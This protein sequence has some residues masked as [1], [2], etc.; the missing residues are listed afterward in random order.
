MPGRS[1]RAGMFERALNSV[2]RGFVAMLAAMLL[3]GCVSLPSDFRQPGVT[4][5]SI[6][7]RVLDSMTPEFDILL[8]VTNPNRKALEISGLIYEVRLAG[9]KVV[10]GVASELPRIDAYGEAD[11]MLRARADLLRSLGVLS[12]LMAN[13]GTPVEY[14]FD[15]EIDLGAFYPIVRVERSGSFIP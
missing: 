11:V 5:V 13:P 9:S 4:V 7:P 14:A 12:Q 1:R 10:E 3:A 8:R 2:R 6:K 15:A